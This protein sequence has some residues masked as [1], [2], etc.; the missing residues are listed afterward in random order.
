MNVW[1]VGLAFMLG[2]LV[3][4][5]PSAVYCEEIWVGGPLMLLA[6]A[7]ISGVLWVTSASRARLIRVAAEL[8][9]LRA[10]L[11]RDEVIDADP[12]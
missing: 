7:V 8:R 10:M 3:D 2:V 1:R 6:L 9:R 5:L 4:R 12:T 11:A